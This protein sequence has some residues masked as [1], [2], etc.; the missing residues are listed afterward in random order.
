MVRSYYFTTTILLLRKVPLGRYFY[1]VG[2]N[3][4]GARLIGIPVNKV[5]IYAFMISGIS[6]A[7]AGCIFVMNIGF[8]PNQTGT[9]LELQDRSRCTRRNSFKRRNRIFIWSCIRSV[10]F[11]NNK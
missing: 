10:I 7:L 6:A 9:G 3:E 1:A 4:D 2:D 8:V 5:K 11:R